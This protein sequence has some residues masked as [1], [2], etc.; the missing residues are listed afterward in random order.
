M[1][2]EALM[3]HA[4]EFAQKIVREGGEFTPVMFAVDA[5]KISYVAVPDYGD[6][7]KKL[8]FRKTL[9]KFLRESRADHYVFVMEMWFQGFT[10]ADKIE[11]DYL[12]SRD[13]KRREGIAVTGVTRDGT[14]KF[15]ISEIK[16]LD[17]GLIAFEPK[18]SPGG[19]I[20]PLNDLFE[21]DVRH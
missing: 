20:G 11:D 21:T 6:P 16:R 2:L 14:K 10:D 4:L 13:P 9:T 1:N 17:F 3:D 7:T 15:Y 5:E 19:A 8:A 12:P 18:K